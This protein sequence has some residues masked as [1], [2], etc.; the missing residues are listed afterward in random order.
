MDYLCINK[1]DCIDDDVLINRIT[2]WHRSFLFINSKLHS[3]AVKVE[4][5]LTPVF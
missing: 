2:R 5:S 1:I 3:Y 4:E